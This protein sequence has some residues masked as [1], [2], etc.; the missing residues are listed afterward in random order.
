MSKIITDPAKLKLIIDPFAPKDQVFIIDEP[1]Q[2]LGRIPVRTDLTVLPADKPSDKPVG[3]SVTE[4][5]GIAMVNPSSVGRLS[6]EWPYVCE[7][8]LPGRPDCRLVATLQDGNLELNV[9]VHPRIHFVATY[10]GHGFAAVRQGTR[11]FPFQKLPGTT[12]AERLCL[13][14]CDE[15]VL[16]TP[17]PPITQ[18][19]AD[20]FWQAVLDEL[21]GTLL[22]AQVM[23]S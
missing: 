23:L 13:R 21:P 5:V 19:L 20:S 8:P 1:K 11:N 4:T 18:L 10:I 17:G 7:W 22:T 16:D 6:V 2:L 3:W 9:H 14:A 15:M 12:D